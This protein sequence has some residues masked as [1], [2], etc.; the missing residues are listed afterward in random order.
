VIPP[1]AGLMCTKDGT[2][3]ELLHRIR[4]DAAGEWWLIR[5][6]FVDQPNRKELFAPGDRLTPLHT[7]FR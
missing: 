5:P 2:P 3:M 7:K 4:T 6:L 1:R